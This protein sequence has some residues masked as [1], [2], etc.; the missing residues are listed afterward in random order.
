MP[1]PSSGYKKMGRKGFSK[2]LAFVYTNYMVAHLSRSE[3]VENEF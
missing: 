1:P 3:S 2:K